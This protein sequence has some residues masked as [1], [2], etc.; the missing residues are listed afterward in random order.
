MVD[1]RSI[2]LGALALVGY[3]GVA[4][5]VSNLYPFSTFPMYA[6]EREPVASRLA[7]READGSLRDPD[8][9]RAWS[10]PEPPS[11]LPP[12]GTCPLLGT[13]RGSYL[14]HD[15]LV[16]MAQH[17]TG[18]GAGE[19]VELVRRVWDLRDGARLETTC[20]IQRCRAVR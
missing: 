8:A 6:V 20:P 9:Y 1:R 18:D 16:F 4:R 14:D 11:A 5:S 17:A 15:F 3:A 2:A 12:P 7:V 13:Q 10:C 19:P